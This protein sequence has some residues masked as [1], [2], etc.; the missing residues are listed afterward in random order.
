MKEKKLM[1]SKIERCP[2]CGQVMGDKH[3]DIDF[4]IAPEEKLVLVKNVPVF[5]CLECDEIAMKVS[6]EEY[7]RKGLISKSLKPEG[8]ITVLVYNYEEK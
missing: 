1:E 5:K 2:W 7:I 4:R 8:H 3:I 6:V